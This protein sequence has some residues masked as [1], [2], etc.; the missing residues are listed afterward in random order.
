MEEANKA[1]WIQRSLRNGRLK[2]VGAKE[3]GRYANI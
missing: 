1:L 3:I 2:A